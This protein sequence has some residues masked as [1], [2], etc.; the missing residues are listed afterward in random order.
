V[1]RLDFSISVLIRMLHRLGVELAREAKAVPTIC[2]RMSRAPLPPLA[3]FQGDDVSNV[4]PPV[5]RV[6][7]QKLPK[8]QNPVV[9]GMSKAAIEI[10]GIH[11][12][13]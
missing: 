9:L 11:C 3:F 10:R 6:Q 1:A 2:Q 13:Q 5:P 8:R 7:R 4:V 12:P